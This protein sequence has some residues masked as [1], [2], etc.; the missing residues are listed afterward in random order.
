MPQDIVRGIRVGKQI[1]HFEK[2]EL[3][4]RLR[5]VATVGKGGFASKN[6]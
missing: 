1:V 3:A 2:N 4:G 5:Q 6:I